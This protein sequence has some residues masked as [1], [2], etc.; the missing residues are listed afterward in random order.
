V[1]GAARA[2]D[3]IDW[4]VETLDIRPG[5]RVLEI[6]SGHGVALTLVAARLED[7]QVTGVDR[8]G[9]MLTAAAKRNATAI[10]AGRV[11]LVHGSWPD[12]DEVL[13]GEGLFS[14]IFAI[15]VPLFRER[16]DDCNATIR[17]LLAPGGTLSV[18]AQPLADADVEP[19]VEATTTAMNAA[20]FHTLPPLI[21]AHQP[22][23]TACVRARVD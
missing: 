18:I 1:A 19:W 5:S 8:S 22:V 3:R 10:E 12:L 23:R 16:P 4:G 15:H 20:G 21:S 17:R 14:H 11:R 6:G 2:S 9:K 7:G 13:P